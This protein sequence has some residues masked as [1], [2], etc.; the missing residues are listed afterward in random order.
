MAEV[1]EVKRFRRISPAAD[2]RGQC[3]RR[4][5]LGRTA[6]GAGRYDHDGA[7]TV[8]AMPLVEAGR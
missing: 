6:A 3:D 7:S 1:M 8:W 5:R 2:A 4:G